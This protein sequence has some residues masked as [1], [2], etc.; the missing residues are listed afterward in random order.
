MSTD[1]PI[2]ELIESVPKLDRDTCTAQLRRF[3]QPRLDFTDEYLDCLSLD[4]LRH[5]LLAAC[6]Q[7]RDAQKRQTR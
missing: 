5:V 7:A 6:L 3:R 4:R 2:D 1:L